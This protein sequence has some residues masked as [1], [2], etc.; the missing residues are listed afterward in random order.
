MYV[1]IYIYVYIYVYVYIYIY[2]YI[3][4]YVLSYDHIAGKRGGGP[5]GGSGGYQSHVAFVLARDLLLLHA[6]HEQRPP[7][8]RLRHL[9]YHLP[10]PTTSGPRQ[11][12]NTCGVH[13]SFHL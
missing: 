10:I 9:L 2:I 5:Q 4:V 3:Y 7:V 11:L 13:W 1:Y 8:E 6:A 12:R